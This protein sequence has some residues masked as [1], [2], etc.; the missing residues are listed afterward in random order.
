MRAAHFSVTE[1]GFA[2]KDESS[3]TVAEAI[4]DNDRVEYYRGYTQALLE[5]INLDGVD[6]RSY[7]A[8]SLLDNFEWADG[9]TT[10]FGVT[11][12][13]YDTQ[14]RAPKDS[15]RFLKEVS[16]A[17]EISEFR[18][19]LNNFKWFEGHKAK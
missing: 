1:N 7:F 17:L 15:S 19:S 16:F 5:A 14:E 2:C 9:Y 8:W 12:I 3:L 10:R 4:H 11:H 13:N 6:I 18:Q